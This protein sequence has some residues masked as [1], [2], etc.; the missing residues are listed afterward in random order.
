MY[1]LVVKSNTFKWD[2]LNTGNYSIH[3]MNY[4][5]DSNEDHYIVSQDKALNCEQEMIEDKEYCTLYKMYYNTIPSQLPHKYQIVSNVILKFPVNNNNIAIRAF[6][7][8]DDY[9]KKMD[10][11]KLIKIL[12]I[13]EIYYEMEDNPSNEQYLSLRRWIE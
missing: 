10:F 4:L 1:H 6:I 12:R 2:K 3:F 5:I 13:R 7:N 9:D 8:P 11:D